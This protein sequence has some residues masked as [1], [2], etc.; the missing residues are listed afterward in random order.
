MAETA[1]DLITN[2]LL[3]LGV[4]ADEET[5]TASMAVGALRKLNN[6]IDA[7]NIE[8]L[9]VYGGIQNV[10]PLTPNKGVYTLGIG[11]DFNIPRPNSINE[12]TIRD[13]IQQQDFPIEIYNESQYA[14]IGLKQQTSNL[15]LGV[16]VDSLYP[17]NNVYLWPIPS[18]SQYSLV[19]WTNGIIDNFNLDDVIALAPGYKRAL[20][21]NLCIELSAS[22]GKEVTPSI[23]RIAEDS[24]AK[25]KAQNLQLNRLEIDPRL[26]V[27]PDGAWDYRTGG[28]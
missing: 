26:T 2:S 13:V 15:P 23:A 4:L 7:W 24:K 12:I 25:L 3:D 18:T 10:F 21:S 20:E 17:L 6:M 5:P 28:Y 11:G 1:L 14:S 9:M 19:M 22:Y 27:S 8:N 16:Y